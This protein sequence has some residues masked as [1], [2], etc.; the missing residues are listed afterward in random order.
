[1]A[2]TLPHF[3][4]LN[5]LACHRAPAPFLMVI[6]HDQSSRPGKRPV[7]L[8]VTVAWLHEKKFVRDLR[9][10]V[11]HILG[12]DFFFL[13]GVLAFLFNL[14]FDSNNSGYSKDNMRARTIYQSFPGACYDRE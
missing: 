4:W 6:F 1:M 7:K 9:H 13:W 14:V 3:T 8:R 2:R 12:V 10:V 5:E 11:D